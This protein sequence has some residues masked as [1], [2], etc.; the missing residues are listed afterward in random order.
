[1]TEDEFVK[2][3]SD[4]AWFC[5][6]PLSDL[7]FIG[8][9][10]LSRLTR[11]KGVKV[12]LTGE[13]SD[14]QFAG[15][16]QL[17]S[18]FL[19][20]P[21][22]SWSSNSLPRLPNDIRL[23]LLAAEEEQGKGGDQKT[24]KNLRIADSPTASYA[25]KQINNVSI[26]SM[27]SL[28]T[29]ESLLSPWAHQEFG[30]QDP[31]VVGVHNLLSGTVRK[32][33]QSKW[34]TLHSALYI[35]QKIILQNILLTALGDRVEMANS[36]EGRQPFLDH[37]LTTYVNGLPPSVKLRYDPETQSLNE[38]WILKE[39]AKPFITEVCVPFSFPD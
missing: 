15:Y 21:D 9:I 27:T 2:N 17:L 5:E 4:A 10:A 13:G 1:M 28:M 30:T 26:I 37:Y 3:Y 16:G 35:W 24:I 22:E 14:E 23:R 31:R 7:N 6:Q 11:E 25:R 20:E 38:K 18:D 33:I 19:R 36:I 32:K 12:I 39:A 29:A 34:H 8:K